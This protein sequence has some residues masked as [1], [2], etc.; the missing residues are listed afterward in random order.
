[1]D[2]FKE[3]VKYSHMIARKELVHGSS[4]NI[5]I[6]QGRSMLIKASG[7][8]MEE[9]R[10]K[11]FVSVDIETLSFKK[12][13][14]RPSCEF[15]MHAFCYRK[16]PDIRCVIHTHPLYATTLINCSVKPKLI[17]PEFV[18]AIGSQIGLIDYIC[19]GTEKLAKKVEQAAV[20]NNVIYLKNHGLLCV[21][22]DLQEAYTR[23]LLAEQMAKMQV[24][25]ISMG[26]NIKP[27]NVKQTKVL[28]KTLSYEDKTE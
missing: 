12:K 14:S 6:K 7:C 23:T 25:A 13:T 16:R 10:Q 4:G 15:K 21:G 27:L 26:K 28:L 1:M 2:K 18:L 19:P 3:L 24:L 20:K 11:D 9:A 17:G 5:S 22:R 8:V